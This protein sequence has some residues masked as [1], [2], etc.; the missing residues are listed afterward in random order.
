MVAQGVVVGH[1]VPLQ[2]SRSI[3]H[4]AYIAV[5]SRVTAC[6]LFFGA[7]QTAQVKLF[8]Y[9]AELG[10]VQLTLGVVLTRRVGQ[11]FGAVAC[12]LID[13]DGRDGRRVAKLRRNDVVNARASLGLVK[14]QR[15]L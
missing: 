15:R 14:G 7:H 1:G 10:L 3:G 2:G 5:A 11:Y 8:E 12:V 9:L 13:A 4:R 6:R